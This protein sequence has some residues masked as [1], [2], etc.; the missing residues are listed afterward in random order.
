VH[1]ARRVH[2][3]VFL[4]AELAQL[5][6][7]AVDLGF[8]VERRNVH[9]EAHQHLHVVRGNAVAEL[10]SVERC[11]RRF[12]IARAE[13]APLEARGLRANGGHHRPRSSNADPI[14][15]QLLI[16]EARIGVGLPR[17]IPRVAGHSDIGEQ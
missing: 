13:A 17:R 8:A 3:I 12:H 6:D 14:R 10:Q 11:L 1:R 4:H 9:P 7:L 16:D 5:C 2:R 15:V